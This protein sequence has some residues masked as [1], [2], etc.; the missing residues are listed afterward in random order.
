MRRLDE[1][2]AEERA[3]TE[4][5]RCRDRKK[6]LPGER[7]MRDGIDER[8]C[9]DR[10]DDGRGGPYPIDDVEIGATDRWRG[11]LGGAL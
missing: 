7:M 5:Q 11:D 4:R 6:E 9:A 1:R 2:Q 8:P 3:D 10:D